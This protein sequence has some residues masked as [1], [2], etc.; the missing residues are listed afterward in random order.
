MENSWPS[1]SS[2]PAVP[3]KQASSIALFLAPEPCPA[4]S[5]SLCVSHKWD[6]QLDMT[7]QVQCTPCKQLPFGTL[8]YRNW[9]T[10]LL[11]AELLCEACTALEA[12][13]GSR[14]FWGSWWACSPDPIN[15]SLWRGAQLG[16]ASGPHRCSTCFPLHVLPIAFLGALAPLS[17]ACSSFRIWFL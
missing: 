8:W 5:L 12:D 9:R 3:G 6:T 1:W 13:S 17:E 4:V 14:E 2:M 10:I 15:T 7:V 16:E 11:S